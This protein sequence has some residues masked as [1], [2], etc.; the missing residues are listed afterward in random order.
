[1]QTIYLAE[2]DGLPQVKIELTKPLVPHN[3]CYQGGGLD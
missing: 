1:M 3:G 2:S